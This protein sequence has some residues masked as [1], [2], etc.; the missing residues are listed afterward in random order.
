MQL[1]A[2]AMANVQAF[3]Q[4]AEPAYLGQVR[5]V[6]AEA[7]QAQAIDLANQP[8]TANRTLIQDA[9]SAA[10][11]VWQH[12]S[13]NRA[14]YLKAFS[15][16]DVDWAIQNAVIV[17]QSTYA[18]IDDTDYREVSM[19]AN[20]DWILRQASPGAKAMLWAHNL[21]IN[22][23][24][25]SMGGYVAA[26]HGSDYLAVGQ[27]LN[28]GQ[29]NAFGQVVVPANY[30]DVIQPWD[31]APSYPGTVEYMLHSTGIPRM[32]LDLRRASS[33]DP[34]SQWISGGMLI[35]Q[36][37]A[38]YAGQTSLAGPDAIYGYDGFGL[39]Y[40]VAQDF[41]ALVFFDQTTPSVLLR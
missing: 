32:I 2:K 22:K 3:V 10:H 18:R 12:L 29:Y 15:A 27:L 31:A 13:S 23:V 16:T 4:Q 11:G 36:I 21:H 1:G 19:A 17:E 35:R 28:A 14:T 8:S 20:I 25:G 33:T 9:T 6:Y 41:D 26:A 37:G 40:R 7:T 30:M 39:S 24:P 34:A 38:V 5:T